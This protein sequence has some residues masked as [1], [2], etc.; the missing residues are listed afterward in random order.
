MPTL[1]PS[2]ALVEIVQHQNTIR[3][4]RGNE[5]NLEHLENW[6]PKL[7]VKTYVMLISQATDMASQASA[8]GMILMCDAILGERRPMV[9]DAQP[10]AP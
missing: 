7:N 9:A 1:E 2:S 10:S 4:K 6:V 5:L 3:F 8:T